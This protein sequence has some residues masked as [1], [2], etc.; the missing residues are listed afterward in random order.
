MNFQ[1]VERRSALT[2]QQF[3]DEFATPGIP[4]IV[5]DLTAGWKAQ[6]LWTLDFFRENYGHLALQVKREAQHGPGQASMTMAQYIDYLKSNQDESP[7]YL[8]SWDFMLDAPELAQDFELPV[9]WKDD[10]ILDLPEELRPRLLWL[11]IGPARTGFRMHVDIGH[12]AAW[13]AQLF[14]SK[15][16]TLFPPSQ[17]PNLYFGR[18]DSFQPDLE[19]YPRFREAKGL[20]CT[21]HAGEAI[22]VPSTWWH[23]TLILEDS[24]A[25]SGNYANQ[26]NIQAVQ[27]WLDERPEYQA[28][29]DALREVAMRRQSCP[30][31]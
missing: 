20:E 25:V 17:L 2:P 1:P 8:A 14:G 5:T 28:V 7:Y 15:R 16:W 19:R 30:T 13:N 11:F 9:Y 27:S 24:V 12:T 10:W 23:Q 6:K 26:H 21:L 29:A 18:V 31:T 22:F 4:V 3:L